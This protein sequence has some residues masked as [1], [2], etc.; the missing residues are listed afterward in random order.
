[1]HKHDTTVLWYV[2][3]HPFPTLVLRKTEIPD[4]GVRSKA[5]LNI[6]RD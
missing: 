3:A 1:M 5:I 2:L 6:S 4:Q